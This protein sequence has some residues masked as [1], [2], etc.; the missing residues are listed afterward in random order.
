MT[1]TNARVLAIG[2]AISILAFYFALRNVDFPHLLASILSAK[3]AWMVL[4]LLSYLANFW[5][6]AI[7]WR[8]LLEPVHRVTAREAYPVM[9]TG[10][11]ANNILPAHL[12][13]LVRMYIGSRIFLVSK[14]EVLATLVLERILDFSAV[15]LIFG[16]VLVT[17]GSLSNRL[18]YAGYVLIA[19]TFL[20]FVLLFVSLRYEPTIT[21]FIKRMVQPLPDRVGRRIVAT[22]S[23][24]MTAMYSMKS[25]RLAFRMAVLSLLQWALVGLAIY[26]ALLSVDVEVGIAAAAVTLVATVLATTLPSAP[27]F[28]GTIQLAFV[29]ALVPYGISESDALAGSVIF[30]MISYS[31]VMISGVFSLKRLNIRVNELSQNLDHP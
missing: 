21:R 3:P 8:D 10:F 29:L 31:F 16:G 18:V 23:L 12:G 27:G 22:F 26:A 24:L 2:I 1:R 11:F 13:E 20:A 15:A 7:R 4:V 28:F 6:K 9:M 14:T 5:L 17:G 30:H 19:L 25:A